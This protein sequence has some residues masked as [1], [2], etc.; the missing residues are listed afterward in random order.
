MKN[1]SNDFKMWLATVFISIP[2][3]EIFLY[4]LMQGVDPKTGEKFVVPERECLMWFLGF[5]FVV[6]ITIL[7]GLMSLAHKEADKADSKAK[8]LSGEDKAYF[9]AEY[10][11]G[12]IVA[13]QETVKIYHGNQRI[14]IKLTEL[15][16]VIQQINEA[17]KAA[18]QT[19]TIKVGEID[20][21]TV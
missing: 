14:R 10:N 6:I 18:D 17:K 9:V 13:Y 11:N 16:K 7:L 12:K 5:F 4:F 8:K 15:N 1:L 3:V 2:L 21:P 19:I 20:Y